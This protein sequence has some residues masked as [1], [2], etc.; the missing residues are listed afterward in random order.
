LKGLPP[1][2]EDKEIQVPPTYLAMHEFDTEDLD[3]KAL[4][5]TADTEW[6]KKIMGA[7]TKLETPVFK[8]AKSYGDG[9]FFHQSVENLGF[10]SS[11]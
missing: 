5:A 4:M 10:T 11:L 9:K 1:R 2:E 6:S 3:M 7:V 8:H